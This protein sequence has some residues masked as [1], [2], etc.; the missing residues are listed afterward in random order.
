MVKTLL[1]EARMIGD[2]IAFRPEA[3]D[4]VWVVGGA[5]Y[6]EESIIELPTLNSTQRC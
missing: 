3:L 2:F 4:G 5:Y 1:R 6:L